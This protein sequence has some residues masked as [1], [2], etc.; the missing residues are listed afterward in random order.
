MPRNAYLSKPTS[1]FET[2]FVI[3][4]DRDSNKELSRPFYNNSF[5]GISKRGSGHTG[6]MTGITLRGLINSYF[7]LLV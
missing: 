5:N 2:D 7:L 3:A 4:L 1:F 6:I